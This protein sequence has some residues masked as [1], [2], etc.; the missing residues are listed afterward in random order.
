LDCI[1]VVITST[2]RSVRVFPSDYNVCNLLSKQPDGNRG[3]V[4]REPHRRRPHRHP[5]RRSAQ[6]LRRPHRQ[7]PARRPLQVLIQR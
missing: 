2:N 3:V 5:H 4:E 7:R 1:V 6:H